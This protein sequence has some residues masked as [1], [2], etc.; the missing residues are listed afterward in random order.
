MSVYIAV[1]FFLLSVEIA[2]ISQILLKYGANKKYTTLRKQYVNRYVISAYLLFLVATSCSMYALSSMPISYAPLLET[3]GYV[4]VGI[5]SYI[6]LK[7]RFTKKQCYG[8]VFIL[9]GI[10][11]S[12]L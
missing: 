2:S 9:I 12:C 4:S 8:Y 7:E 11:I 5:L 3:L 10:I 1:F 6:F